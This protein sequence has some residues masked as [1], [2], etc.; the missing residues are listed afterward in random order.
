[1]YYHL[2][3]HVQSFFFSRWFLNEFKIQDIIMVKST[4][5]RLYSHVNPQTHKFWNNWGSLDFKHVDRHILILH[6]FLTSTQMSH[7]KWNVGW[8]YHH[9]ILCHT[10]FSQGEGYFHDCS[11]R[12]LFEIWPVRRNQRGYMLLM[13]P[14]SRSDLGGLFLLFKQP[15]QFVRFS[16]SISYSLY[17]VSWYQWIISPWQVFDSYSDLELSPS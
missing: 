5:Y 17:C 11:T 9:I 7:P 13:K 15:W 12:I 2:W 16:N 10:S 8:L 4:P 14:P 1:M 6:H 3:Y